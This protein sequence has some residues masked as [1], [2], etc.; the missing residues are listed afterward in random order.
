M[1]KQ[2]PLKKPSKALEFVYKYWITA[3]L[4]LALLTLVRQNFITNQF[5]ISLA[6]KQAN[7]QQKIDKNQVL[8]QKNKIKSIELKAQTASDQE[9]LESQAR[10]RFGLIKDGEIY[11]QINANK[12]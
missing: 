7:I 4:L 8:N 11:Y 9:V 12:P 2:K 3:V 1:K 5:P 6:N 10:Y